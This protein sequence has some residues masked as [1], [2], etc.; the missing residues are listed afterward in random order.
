MLKVILR[1]LAA[2][3]VASAVIGATGCGNSD[4]Q[5]CVENLP[6]EPVIQLLYPMPGAT[7]VPSGAGVAIFAGNGI[8]PIT[9]IAGSTTISTTL[10][11]VPSPLPSPIATPGQILPSAKLFA[12]SFGPLARGTSYLAAAIEEPSSPCGT[13]RFPLGSFTTQ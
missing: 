10:R 1:A 11:A 2:L 4:P 9:L 7:N 13:V 3:I 12:V 8:K 6:A 5:P